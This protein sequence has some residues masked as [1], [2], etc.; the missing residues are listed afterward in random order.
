[1]GSICAMGIFGA[2]CAMGVFHFSHV[3]HLNSVI[4]GWRWWGVVRVVIMLPSADTCMV[5]S[6]AGIFGRNEF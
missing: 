1:V 4:L 2:F 6:S 5:V 3:Q